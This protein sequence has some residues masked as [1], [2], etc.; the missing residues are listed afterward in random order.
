MKIS[1]DDTVYEFDPPTT[2]G[3]FT[4]PD[5]LPALA[6]TL[7]RGIG[8]TYGGYST[9][10]FADGMQLYRCSVTNE[11]YRR[12]SHGGPEGYCMRKH[13]V[14]FTVAFW[15]LLR[16]RNEGNPLW[17][18]I[19]GQSYICPPEGVVINRE[20]RPGEQGRGHSGRAFTIRKFNG[21]QL[22]VD[23]LWCQGMIPKWLMS[24]LPNNAEFV[25]E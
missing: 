10:G 5:G 14:S 12:D 19:R 1:I 3:H 21:E 22:V 25:K 17:F 7:G 20:P 11:L 23:D 15:M 18:I 6:G 4:A 8:L 24:E 2:P 16:E 9:S 13:N